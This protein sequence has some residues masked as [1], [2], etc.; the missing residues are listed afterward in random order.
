M[1][2]TKVQSVHF[3]KHGVRM[4][5]YFGKEQLANAGLL[6]LEVDA[7][8]FEEFYHDKSAFIYYVL[9]GEGSFFLNCKE[10]KVRPTD[11]IAAPPGTKIYYLGK[12]RLLLITA[13]AWEE[14]FEHHVRDVPR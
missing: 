12:M 2:Y 14:K 10:Y 4:R 13:P 9:E 1:K 8:H 11:V 7:G 3:E 5:R 6:Y